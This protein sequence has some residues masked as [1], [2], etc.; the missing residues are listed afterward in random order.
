MAFT[1]ATLRC[2]NTLA[3]LDQHTTPDIKYIGG[4]LPPQMEV[5]DPSYASECSHPLRC[6]MRFSWRQTLLWKNDSKSSLKPIWG[7]CPHPTPPSP[8]SIEVSHPQPTHPKP[9]PSQ[10][11]K[12][13]C[14]FFIQCRYE[15]SNSKC[16]GSTRCAVA[17]VS[18]WWKTQTICGPAVR[19][20]LSPLMA[21]VWS[22]CRWHHAWWE[23][24]F[25]L[26]WWY[27][28]L[29]WGWQC[30]CCHMLCGLGKVQE[31][32]A[33]PNLQPPLT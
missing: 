11:K 22:G 7:E 31:S 9:S 20:I 19:V 1:R 25:L 13:S 27:A 28:V 10:E 5:I 17:W 29:R 15:F 30:H 3:C 12:Q 26:P 32:L 21:K 33:C 8:Q 24:H 2:T 16:C 18:D 4:E 6:V 14:S 23:S